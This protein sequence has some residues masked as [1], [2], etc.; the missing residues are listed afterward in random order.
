M[1]GEIGVQITLRQPER[2]SVGSL[3]KRRAEL[4]AEYGTSTQ[5]FV[6]QFRSGVLPETP[7]FVEWSNLNR[8][9]S[10]LA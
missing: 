6:E 3:I 1:I 8:A 10:Y 2:V 4:E 5:S 7:E 9:I